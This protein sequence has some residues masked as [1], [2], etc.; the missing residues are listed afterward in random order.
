M[1][2]SFESKI[3]YFQKFQTEFMIYLIISIYLRVAK[4]SFTNEPRRFVQFFHV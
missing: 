4:V 2:N 3:Q 1:W